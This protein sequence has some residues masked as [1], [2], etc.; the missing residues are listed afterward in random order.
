MRPSDIC[1]VPDCGH[2]RERHRDDTGA[3]TSAKHIATPGIE[4]W[5]MCPCLKFLALQEA[6]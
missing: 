6:A 1:Q 5:I 3:C 2:T 4:Q